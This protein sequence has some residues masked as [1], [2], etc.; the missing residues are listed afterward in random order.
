MNQKSHIRSKKE[1]STLVRP[2]YS[3]GLLLND[4]DLTAAVDYTRDLNRMLFKSL[5]GCGVVCGL[6]VEP[7]VLCAKLVVTVGAG[8][9]L[10]C[11]GDPVHVPNPSKVE[12]DPTCGVDVPNRLWVLLRRY[13]KH[14]A[15]R[16]A[17][18]SQDDDDAASVCTRIRD[19]YEV[20]VVSTAP[21]CG[22]GCPEPAPPGEIAPMPGTTHAMAKA[23]NGGKAKA[24]ASAM[25]AGDG[26]VPVIDCVAKASSPCDPCYEDHYAGVCSLCCGD[27]GGCCEWIVLARLDQSSAGVWSANHAVRRFIRP[28][29][30]T[31][32]QVARE[33]AA[34]YTP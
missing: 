31:D 13:D 33:T 12:I 20:S 14:C 16:S 25:V 27:G 10:D 7:E 11:H 22:C 28:M 30:M 18:C 2:Q 21:D 26:T 6:V 15:P 3:P 23:G 5:L 24:K 1:P 34:Q 4:D 17:L 32:P 9:A 8:V 19:G 29:L